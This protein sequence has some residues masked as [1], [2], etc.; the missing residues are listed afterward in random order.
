MPTPNQALA[1]VMAQAVVDEMAGATM[2]ILDGATTLAEVTLPTPAGTVSNG[3]ITWDCD[4][5]L[6][7]SSNNASGDADGG[8]VDNGSGVVLEITV[9]VGSGDLQLDTLTFVSGGTFTVQSFTTTVQN[10]GA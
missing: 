3:V 9:G 5:D 1:T 4:P 8:E 10:T 2:R 6:V 7:D